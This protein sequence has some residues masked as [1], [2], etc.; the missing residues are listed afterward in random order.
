MAADCGVNSKAEVEIPLTGRQE[1]AS[2]LR[3]E[4]VVSPPSGAMD[5]Q[6]GSCQM[7]HKC[8]PS[9]KRLFFALRHA[10]ADK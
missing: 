9:T 1:A 5:K 4:E 3:Q 10:G 2:R 7:V 8:V 6:F